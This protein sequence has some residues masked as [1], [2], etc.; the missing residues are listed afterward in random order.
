MKTTLLTTILLVPIALFSQIIEPTRYNLDSLHYP[1]NN[2]DYKYIRVVENYKNQPN[3]FIF[4]EYYKSGRTL[5]M[6]AISTNKDEPKFEGSRIDY[7]EDG[8]KKRETNY[9]N[10]QINGKQVEW[11]KNQNKKSEKEIKTDLKTLITTTQIFQYW[12]E[13]NEQKVID[14]NGFYEEN[15]KGTTEK[16]EIKNGR[17]Q[18]IWTGKT[19]LTNSTYTETYENGELISGVSID[20][21]NIEHPYQV[22]FTKPEYKEGMAAF[23]QFIGK[24]YRVPYGVQSKPGE[25]PTLIAFFIVDTDGKIIDIKI[26]KDLGLGTGKEAIRV[27]KKAPN[28]IPGT[29][30]GILAKASYTLPIAIQTT[31]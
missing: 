2:K 24:N 4:T 27:L 12:N 25:K 14:G 30:R 3:L 8:N 7:Y 19:K 10:N 1:T 29:Y 31:Q 23:Y 21:N 16:G 9:R 5:S 17:K 15:N 22:L 13:N 11:Y 20:N 18:G 6:K 28:W 26:A